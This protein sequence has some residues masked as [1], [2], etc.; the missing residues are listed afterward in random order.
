MKPVFFL[1]I[2]IFGVPRL[3]LGQSG[4]PDQLGGVNEFNV[5]DELRE[6]VRSEPQLQIN[7]RINPFYLSGDFDG[8]G[9]TDFVVQVKSVKG[10]HLG[11][12]F[13]FANRKRSIWEIWG[14]MGTDGMFTGFLCE[15]PR[16]STGYVPSVPALPVQGEKRTLP[17]DGPAFTK[18]TPASSAGNNSAAGTANSFDSRTRDVALSQVLFVPDRC[19][20]T[21]GV[22]LPD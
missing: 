18:P 10:E 17:T 15:A 16:I 14:N 22:V 2:L 20:R 9:I 19:T 4:S 13:C 8:D 7:G 11:V 1:L 3:L 12:L 21:Y 5:P 6:C